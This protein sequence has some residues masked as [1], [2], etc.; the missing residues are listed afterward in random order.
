MRIELKSIVAVAFVVLMLSSIASAAIIVQGS[1][2]SISNDTAYA[3][4]LVRA[5]VLYAMLNRSL[6]LNISAELRSEIQKLLA[7]NISALPV[8][9]LREWV[10]NASRLLARVDEEVRVGGRAYAVGI[11]L[12]R[13][14]NG[15][16]KALEEKLRRMGIEPTNITE[17]KSFKELDKALKDYEKVLEVAKARKF[18]NSSIVIALQKS[19]KD[20]KGLESAYIH[21]SITEKAIDAT[22]ARLRKLNAS[23]DAIEGLQVAL[24]KVREAKEILL[25]TSKSLALGFEA[26]VTKALKSIAENKSLEAQEAL[27]E[28][29]EEL[30]NLKQMALEHNATKLA[31]TID[32]VI[33][34]LQQL[35]SRLA[36]ASEEDLVRWLPDLLEIRG[37]IKVIE[38][39]INTTVVAPFIV[40]SRPG[41]DKSFI[42]VSTKAEELLQ[43][44]K[45]MLEKVKNASKTCS[46]IKAR[47]QPPYCNKLYVDRVEIIV[48]NAEGMLSKAEDLYLKGEKIEALLLA[49]RALAM[50]QAAKAWLQP[51]YNAAIHVR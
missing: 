23:E 8:D 43:E 35:K 30:Q 49:N 39:R 46:A 18:V 20:A 38:R 9:G 16:K 4:L 10:N 31:E 22:I 40:I 36:N 50:L 47:P 28:L 32:S 24:E 26:N 17:A 13:Y 1:Q 44:V 45:Q 42:V 41:L 21:L 51:L 34:E 2:Q 48:K 37:W 7:V 5:R 19:L 25:N 14:L 11:A 29:V 6:A 33:N 15:L 27:D 12:Q 3:V